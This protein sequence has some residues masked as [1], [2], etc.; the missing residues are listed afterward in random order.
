MSHLEIPLYPSA[1]FNY[2][3]LKYYRGLDEMTL[4]RHFQTPTDKQKTKLPLQR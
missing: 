1:S 3:L 2:V 4:L